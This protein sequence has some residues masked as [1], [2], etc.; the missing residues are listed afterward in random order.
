MPLNA[1]AT[2]DSRSKFA[3]Y[4]IT[5]FWVKLFHILYVAESPKINDLPCCNGNARINQMYIGKDMQLSTPV[6]SH[7]R[8]KGE[9]ERGKPE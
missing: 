2:G 9:G 5:A 6:L 3:Y 1:S 8:E 7:Q 4:H